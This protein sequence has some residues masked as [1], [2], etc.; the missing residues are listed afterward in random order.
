MPRLVIIPTLN[1][2]ENLEK[3]IPAIFELMPEVSVIVVDDNSRDGSHELIRGFQKTRPNLHLLVRT[4]D[5]GY[6]RSVLAGLDFALE[7]GFEKVATMDADFSH[8]YQ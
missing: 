8:D 2:R 7:R 1:E 3:L 4:A 5:Q 6:G